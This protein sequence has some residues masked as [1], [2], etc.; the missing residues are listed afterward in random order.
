MTLQFPASPINSSKFTATNGVQYQWD[1]E[2]WDSI[3]RPTSLNLT[4]NP[5]PNPPANP[6]YGM[7]WWDTI[8]GQLFTY[9][10]DGSSE[11][12]IETSTPHDSLFKDAEAF[13]APQVLYEDPIA[14]DG[15]YPLY[16]NES[17][18][19]QSS[20]QSSSHTHNIRGVTYYM[21]DG[22][23]VYHGTY[24]VTTP[25]QVHESAPTPTPTP[26]PTPVPTPTPTPTPTPS[27]S[28]YSGGYY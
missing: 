15:F 13:V 12:W 26:T 8:S 11:Q 5:G 2:K 25:D 3:T 23:Q 14:V 18:S 22:I 6:D 17:A 19:N 28:P 21:P 9:F 1:G 10:F 24:G 20:P 7:L 16:I 4:T 27:P